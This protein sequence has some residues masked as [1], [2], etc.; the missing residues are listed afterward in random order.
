[1][2]GDVRRFRAMSGRFSAPVT[3]GDELTVHI[4]DEP[5]D[6]GA[7]RT[8]LFQTLRGDGTVVLDRGRAEVGPPG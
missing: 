6:G 4:W 2:D 7:D 1:M 5:G 8:V 3:P